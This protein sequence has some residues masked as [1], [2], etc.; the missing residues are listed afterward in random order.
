MIAATRPARAGIAAACGLVVAVSTCHVACADDALY[1]A[2]KNGP[3]NDP[4]FFPISV[5]WQ[6]PA[7]TGKSGKYATIAAAAV[8]M[9]IN[10]ILGIGGWPERYGRDDGELEA[11]KANR[12]YAIGGIEVPP[13]DTTSPRSIPSILALAHSLN[14]NSNLIGYN[15]GDEPSCKPDTIGHVP[16][17]I[18]GLRRQDSSRPI[19]FNQTTWMITPQWLGECKDEALS[20]VRTISIGSFDFY[21]LTGPWFPQ[22]LHYPKGDFATTPNDSLWTQG[23]ATAAL[24]HDGRPSQPMWVFIEAGGDNLGFSSGNNV[25]AGGV[26]AGSATVTNVS[27][28]SVFTSTWLGLTLSGSGIPRGAK[29]TRIIDA[30]HAVLSAPASATSMS[31]LISVTGGAG[32]G[33]DCVVRTN[34]CVVNGNEY[35]PRAWEVNAEVWMS[36]INGANG[37]E[38]FCHDSSSDFFCMGDI[39]GGAVAADTQANLTSINSTVRR[40]ASVLNASS[41]GICSMQHLN[42]ITGESS[43]TTWCRDGELEISTSDAAVPG[44]AMVKRSGGLTYLF[45]QSDRRSSSGAVFTCTV[46]GLA[47]QS[48][49]V[50]YD[51]NERYDARH[52]AQK[53]TFILDKDDKFSDTLGQ[54]H[55][56][57]QVK[58]YQIGAAAVSKAAT[59][60]LRIRRGGA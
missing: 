52:V 30:T 13:N 31:E 28:W 33:T 27:G 29:I 46:R 43:T 35:R 6:N 18:D 44:M 16:A 9:H 24:I 17:I 34:L 57:Y 60:P 54:F 14:A 40:F 42:E 41:K 51:S 8:G 50:V 4:T 12:L 23:M 58:I 48:A 10:I 37:I 7:L 36:L 5:W 49:R 39:G 11:V 47:G 45:V 59:S 20:A 15:A 21:P 26:A 55:D 1:R 19:M 38:Y 32:S 25:F 56:D 22:V 2:W 3:P 53:R